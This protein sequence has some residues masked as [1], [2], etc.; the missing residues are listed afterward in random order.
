MKKLLVS[1][2]LLIPALLNSQTADKLFSDTITKRFVE[3]R[4][5]FPQEKIYAQIDKPYYIT[6][7]DIWFRAFLVDASHHIPDTTSR[8]I[9]AELVN[10]IDSVVNR[11]KVRPVAGA[12]HGYIPLAE[13]L[14]EGEYYLRFYTRFMEGLG[15]DFFFKRKVVIGDPLSALYRTDLILEE[16][17][18]K[19]KTNVKLRF[20][21]ANTDDV[22]YPDNIVVTEGYKV[23][24]NLKLDSDNAAR[25]SLNNSDKAKKVLMVEYD[26]GK[27]YHRQFVP[28]LNSGDD[29][30]VSFHPEG[31]DIPADARVMI[32]FKALNSNGLGEDIEG[33]VVSETGDTLTTFTSMHLGMGSFLFKASVD[34]KYYA[35]CRNSKNVEKR[36]ELPSAKSASVALQVKWAKSRLNIIVQK[37]SDI[38][39]LP[40]DL[41]LV[42]HTRGI[43]WYADKWNQNSDYIYIDRSKL[44]TGVS[45]IMLVTPDM[46]PLSERLFFNLNRGNLPVA[47]L[48]TDKI[49]YK[50]RELVNADIKLTN[51][52][53]EPL[54]G[55]LS[56]AI[57]DDKDIRPDTCSNDILSSLLLTS[58]LKGY[59]ESPLYYFNE[60]DNSA[61][62]HLDVL[63]MTQ[64]WTRYNIPD[65]MKGIYTRPKSYLELS[66]EIS[67][68]VQG[69]I[70]M[71]R[72]AVD[73]P[74]SVFVPKLM[75]YISTQTDT[76]GN[77]SFKGFELPD[78]T[79]YFIQATTKKGGKR[80]ELKVNRESFPRVSSHMPMQDIWSE[81]NTF[82]K[83]LEKAEQKYT[84][85]NGIRMIYLKDIEVV[86]SD[87]KKEPKSI[88]ASGINSQ[89]YTAEDIEQMHAHDIKSVLMRM[90]GVNVLGDNVT[91]RGALGPPLTMI[92]NVETGLETFLSI[93]IFDVDEVVVMKGA[94]TTIFG[95]RGMNGAILITTKRGDG[96]VD[97]IRENFNVKTIAPL[98][99]QVTK[100]FYMPRYKTADEINN[101]MPDLRSTI[102]WNPSIK[103]S[104]DG[105]AK[106]QF[107][108]ADAT[109]TYSV[110]IEGI[111]N[112]GEI[113]RAVG[114]INRT[115]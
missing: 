29:Y 10:P 12:Y 102:Y 17:D 35:I 57:R 61:M 22:I 80:V 53:G 27:K 73:N 62:F 104:E 88:Y 16:N 98:G 81:K 42:I 28:V 100:E 24:E 95:S 75:M 34:E 59:I 3:Q 4:M 45:S 96:V 38:E 26:Y 72:K 48:T 41:Y 77:F 78:S 31:G 52:D 111:T 89:Y 79:E 15:E 7:E 69:G 97:R 90:A 19:K 51:K 94:E 43:V 11:V 113:V 8:Y 92:D 65:V 101:P 30:D 67:G 60:E 21:D 36:F 9:Y 114:K 107:N 110:V 54:V 93:P 85:E 56:V 33:V 44:P 87:K 103:T 37:S 91:I 40:D 76:E 20:T 6:G 50:N 49:K 23:F 32:A 13:D 5:L 74:V 105:I 84:T 18:N 71:N 106:I 66:Q 14:P 25:I 63:M 58:D 82:G 46:I 86:G 108:T 55:D 39:L 115:D 2:I 70:L 99:Y 112:R 68:K 64:G 1:L 47:S 83:Y 109:S